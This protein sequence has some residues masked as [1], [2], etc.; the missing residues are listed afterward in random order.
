MARK[1]EQATLILENSLIMQLI[2]EGYDR[3][4]LVNGKT[5]DA[6]IELYQI[7]TSWFSTNEPIASYLFTFASEGQVT[8][9]ALAGANRVTANSY[10]G[11]TV[12]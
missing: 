1:A 3:V 12:K 4:E 9:E 10:T 8:V 2:R 7:S 5:T 11:V 6:V